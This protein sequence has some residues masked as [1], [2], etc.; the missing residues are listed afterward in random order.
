MNVESIV[1]ELIFKELFP[2]GSSKAKWKGRGLTSSGV[3]YRM[4]A[5]QWSHRAAAACI[6]NDV[7]VYTY[8]YINM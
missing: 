2:K 6:Y 4:G 5:R 7:R 3:L 8:T 1:S